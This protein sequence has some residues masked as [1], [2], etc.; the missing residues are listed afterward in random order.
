M[1]PHPIARTALTLALSAAAVS[2]AAADPAEKLGAVSFANSCSEAVQPYLQRAVAMLHSFWWG[3]G[4]KAFHDVLQR[5]P[6]CAIAGW[7]IAAIAIGNP[8]A[9]GAPPEAAKKAQEAIDQARKI[10]AKSE[11]ERG[12][13]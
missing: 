6:G 8:Y 4:D 1:M 9:S 13:I 10:G 12:Y 3:E 11:R 2:T 7:G 5:D